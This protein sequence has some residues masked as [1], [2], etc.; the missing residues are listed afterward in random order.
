MKEVL[1]HMFIYAIAPA[2][3]IFVAYAVTRRDV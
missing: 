3:V 1:F 2:F